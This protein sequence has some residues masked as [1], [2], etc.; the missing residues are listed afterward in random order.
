MLLWA[1][2]LGVHCEETFGSKASKIVGK[3]N[4]GGFSD[5]LLGKSIL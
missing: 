4:L 1:C 2:T 3:L 5:W